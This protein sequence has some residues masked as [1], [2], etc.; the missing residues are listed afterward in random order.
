MG[1]PHPSLIEQLWRLARRLLP[2]RHIGSA[3]KVSAE[4]AA[5]RFHLS[6][7]PAVVMNAPVT[8]QRFLEARAR[9]APPAELFQLRLDAQ[10]NQ[11]FDRAP[12]A[13]KEAANDE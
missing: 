8:L 5:T 13:R 1:K 4:P 11:I 9:G 7:R 2:R 12:C 3:I 10:L 6:A